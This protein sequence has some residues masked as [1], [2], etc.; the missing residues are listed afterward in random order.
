MAAVQRDPPVSRYLVLW[1]VI[2]RVQ[3]PCR[4]AS[5]VGVNTSNIT[6]TKD[7]FLRYSSTL[8]WRFEVIYSSGLATSTSALHLRI[9]PPPSNGPC[10]IS[11]LI[12]NTSTLFTLSCVNWTDTDGIKEY[13]LYGKSSFCDDK[14]SVSMLTNRLEEES[15]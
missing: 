12:G 6:A 10:S 4:V 1:S 13:S 2:F 5:C 3:D 9:N 7:L 11:P 8:Y 15:S 14:R